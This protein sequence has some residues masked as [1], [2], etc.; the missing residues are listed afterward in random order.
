MQ[1]ILVPT[2]F[3]PEARNAAMHA[4]ELARVLNAKVMLFHAY[5]LPTPVSEVPYVMVTVDELQKE[6]E[7]HIKKEASYLH[8]VYEL[9]IEWLVRIG[10]PS[11]EIKMVAEEKLVDLVVMGMKGTGG[12][13]D[14]IIGSTTINAIRKVQSPILIVPHD[15]VYR[16]LR[17]IILATDLGVENTESTLLPLL[18]IASAFKSTIQIVNVHREQGNEANRQPD[19]SD[20]FKNIFKDIPHGFTVI[21]DTSVMHGINEY[22]QL[23]PSELLVMIAHKHSFLERVFSKNHTT[24]MAH[25]TKIPLLILHHPRSV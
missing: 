1:T 4:A 24:A 7:H 19:S 20:N 13:L 17:N 3:S 12:G 16:A 15:A 10:I 11:D 8:D 9:E 23:H 2:D 18:K 6:N 14:I 5:M 25:E 21:T 22:I